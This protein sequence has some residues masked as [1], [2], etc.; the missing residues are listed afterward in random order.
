[1][2]EVEPIG[3]RMATSSGRNGNATVA[4]VA[5]NHIFNNVRQGAEPAAA[6]KLIFR[7]RTAEEVDGALVLSFHFSLKTLIQSDKKRMQT[8]EYSN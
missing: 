8:C 7:S 2:L 4:G 6:Y 1:M 3:H 5:Q